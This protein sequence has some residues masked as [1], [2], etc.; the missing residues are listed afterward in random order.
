MAERNNMLKRLDSQL[1][2]WRLTMLDV[3]KTS[4]RLPKELK[5]V[6]QIA[7]EQ[8]YGKLKGAQNDAFT[9]SVL[10][11]LAHKQSLPVVMI[12]DATSAR[13]RVVLMSQLQ[14]NLY[15]LLLDQHRPQLGIVP[16]ATT[17]FPVGIISAT[18]KILFNKFG[19]PKIA[20]IQNLDQGETTLEE[21]NPKELSDKAPD[22]FDKWEGKLRS[23]QDG[24]R[25]RLELSL[26]WD[27]PSKVQASLRED[28]MSV[29]NS[30]QYSSGTTQLF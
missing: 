3:D 24:T 21:L 23:M 13:K 7:V 2:V 25:D 4:I 30:N 5:E 28:Y 22:A 27:S 15:E 19:L 18:A 8:E 29:L 12:K 20:A 16:I 26:S 6:F 17:R 11:W 9:E 14:E 10:L 1:L